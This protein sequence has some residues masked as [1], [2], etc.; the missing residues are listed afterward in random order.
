M[1]IDV[2]IYLVFAIWKFQCVMAHLHCRRCTPVRTW[3]RIP[4]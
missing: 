3:T 1:K 4:V 2:Y